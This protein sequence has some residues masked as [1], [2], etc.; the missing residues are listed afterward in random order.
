[1]RQR[2]RAD[3]QTRVITRDVKMAVL[4]VHLG[5]AD[6]AAQLH[7]PGGPVGVT[8]LV[9]APSAMRGLPVDGWLQ[10]EPRCRGPGPGRSHRF[11]RGSVDNGHGERRGHGGCRRL[12]RRGGRGTG[13]HRGRSFPQLLDFAN[14]GASGPA[15]L[16]RRRAF[17]RGHGSQKCND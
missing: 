16:P 4:H 6:A 14:M 5:L 8:S 10:G 17:N 9:G 2:R 1:V 13:R 11:G 12:C 15:P 3:T 7:A